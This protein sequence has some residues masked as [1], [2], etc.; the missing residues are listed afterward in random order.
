[1]VLQIISL[2]GDVSQV[3]LEVDQSGWTQEIIEH[4]L[5]EGVQTLMCMTAQMIIIRMIVMDHEDANLMGEVPDPHCKMKSGG[6]VVRALSSPQIIEISLIEREGIQVDGKEGDT[7]MI[8]IPE[9][10][11]T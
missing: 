5:T 2:N 8:S 6:A 4:H 10:L 11:R 9:T 1:M 7:L 3:L